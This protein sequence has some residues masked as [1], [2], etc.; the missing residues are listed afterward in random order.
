MKKSSPTSNIV[1]AILVATMQCILPSTAQ[2]A[3]DKALTDSMKNEFA[4]TNEYKEQVRILHDIIDIDEINLGVS[5]W[6]RE[7]QNNNRIL[8][9]LATRNN[10]E[11]TQLEAMRVLGT[12]TGDHRTSID[13]IGSYI[14]KVEALPASNEQ[15]EVLVYLRCTKLQM[16]M[17]YEE[18]SVTYNNLVRMI[19]EFNKTK[20][21]GNI[22]D[23]IEELL[24]LCDIMYKVC[25]E[26]LYISYLKQLGGLVDKLPADGNA[27]LPRVYVT[28]AANS[29]SHKGMQKEAYKANVTALQQIE[30][31]K[32]RY[33]KEGRSYHSY[34]MYEYVIYRRMLMSPD[35][36]SPA[37]LDSCFSKMQDLA[38]SNKL[39]K[40]DFDVPG[41]ISKIRYYMATKRYKEAIPY[42]DIRL[43]QKDKYKSIW[44]E[45]IKY[46][47]TAGKA[48]G[49]DRDLERYALLYIDYLERKQELDIA[50]KA[51]ELQIAYDVNALEQQVSQL[52]LDKKES[53]IRTSMIVVAVSL[54]AFVVL[55]IL[56]IVVLRS[57]KRLADMNEDLNEARGKA[58]N[59]NRMK[60]MFI[61]NMNHEIRTPMNAMVGFSKIIA[62]DDGSLTKEERSA[63]SRIVSDNSDMLLTM[64]NDLLD[65]SELEAGKMKFAIAPCSMNDVCR[66][67]IDSCQSKVPEGV[68]LLFA[69]QGPDVQANTDKHRVSQ[70]INNYI[71]NACKNTE[72]GHISVD[73]TADSDNRKITLSV[74]DTGRGVPA[75]KTNM[76]F[77][78]FEKLDD[79]K[80]G[81]GI[82]LNI[83]SLIADG[84]KG[85][86][87]L[88]T[89]YTGGARFLFIFPY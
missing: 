48:L 47:I 4:K 66:N 11:H 58:E 36:M 13:S 5:E 82:G 88:D 40:K 39:V 33:G 61:Q 63:Y 44:N 55:L 56:L 42:L 20:D 32:K 70:V 57:R 29:Y 27:I 62:E 81:A 3:N 65:I 31:L 72:K 2:T 52:E 50:A 23:R 6:D 19:G 15:R 14:K 73:Y 25:P 51:R 24:S 69:H 34:G 71:S 7:Y 9:N 76:I 54:T 1:F 53:Q 21:Y 10:D 78:R 26:D 59:A 67:A 38:N 89:S 64:V 46:R 87:K 86:V 83:C 18:D 22:Y 17:N 16:G 80:D 28:L 74:T 35:V 68:T 77:Q 79:F 41:S 75:D 85:E 60:T 43:D 37:Q 30:E 49:D 12:N 8:M 84:L 45:C